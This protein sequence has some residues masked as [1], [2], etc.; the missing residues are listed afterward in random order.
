M[1]SR[2]DH[3]PPRDSK[4]RFIGD[5]ANKYVAERKKHE[6][7]EVRRLLA[8][9]D[10][11]MDEQMDLVEQLNAGNVSDSEVA[12]TSC[13]KLLHEALSKIAASN[14][15]PMDKAELLIHVSHA[16]TLHLDDDVAVEA[17]RVVRHELLPETIGAKIYTEASKGLA[18]ALQ[19]GPVPLDE[20]Y[21]VGVSGIGTLTE[22]TPNLR[23][24]IIERFHDLGLT[25]VNDDGAIIYGKNKKAAHYLATG[26]VET[27]RLV[28][29]IFATELPS[30]IYSLDDV[31]AA[32][33]SHDAKRQVTELEIRSNTN[34]VRILP[35]N[36]L[37][38]G[39]QDAV[40]GLRLVRQ[41]IELIRQLPIEDQPDV[42]LVTNLIQGD[43]AHHQAR[44]RAALTEGLDTN[45]NQFQAAHL[46]LDELRTLGIPIVLSLGRD[47][48]S[49]ALD[50]TKD[51]MREMKGIAS[52]GTRENFIP[53]YESNKLMQDVRFQ[54]H[55]RFQLDYILPLCYTI[56]RRL[57]SADEVSKATGGELSHSEYLAL[58]A[59]I[60]QGDELP[61]ELGIEPDVLVKLGDWREGMCIVDDV[62]FKLTTDEAEHDVLYRHS[63]SG[64]TPE[65]LLQNHMDSLIG[66]LGAMGTNGFKQPAA[67][68]TGGTQEGVFATKNNA[69]AIALPGLGDPA[70]SH[71]RNQYSTAVPGDPTRRMNLLRK[72]PSS[73][74]IEMVAISDT[75]ETILTYINKD[76]MDRADSLPRTAIF[77]LCDFQIG[78]P[79]ARPDYQ[80]KYLSYMLE[81]A[82]RMPIVIQFAGDIIH[83]HIYPGFSDESQ[84]IGLIRIKSQKIMVSEMLR[85]TFFSVPQSLI[86]SIVDVLVQQ[87]NHDEVQRTRIPNN[88][89]SNIDYIIKDFQ[90]IVDR[91]GEPSR[92]RH[93]A[94]YHTKT[95]VPVPTWMGTSHYGAYTVKT[96]HYH[97][98]RGA[99]GNTGGLPVYHAY[100]RAVGLGEDEQAQILMGAHWHN[101]QAAVL[102]SKLVVVGGAMAE[103]SQFEDVRGYSARLAGT[104]VEI[105]GK[106]P[107]SV[108]FL[109]AATLDA[110]EIKHGYF[111]PMNLAENGYHDDPGFDVEKHGPYSFDDRPKSALQKALSHMARRASQLADF[112]TDIENPNLYDQAT[113]LP[114]TLNP[115]TQ[116]IFE[117][118]DRLARTN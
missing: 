32:H 25:A 116:R 117:A 55:L 74:A 102:G 113:G 52:E 13:E 87:G 37:R 51:V 73:P 20:E 2:I 99:K 15:Q 45:N 61:A 77:E 83:G 81:T 111:T 104:V 3:Q 112:S 49:I 105:G 70:K 107:T 86:D 88:N 72:R 8:S 30:P 108:R 71:N 95:G 85:K 58:Y 66:A 80:I 54:E 41:T 82:K 21:A 97:L 100:Q 91:P 59:H 16:M 27:A 33:D 18:R 44:R 115:E 60:M 9:L 67:I 57:R 118:S 36:E 98:D 5:I 10:E 19:D 34:Q 6:P 78:S 50:Y 68:M 38:L 110:H 53:Y 76:I 69:R 39:H 29:K 35:I 46:L 89:D 14:M 103:Q 92:V 4:G 40:S 114:L 43:F 11:L 109:N 106:L 75:G 79:T 28:S 26:A 64:Y 31:E 47:D 7:I 94:I 48:H 17:R 90:S 24:E 101:P 12:R 93:N 1:V 96:A 23:Q 42:I 63:I 84:S 65:T 56:G 22:L 62:N